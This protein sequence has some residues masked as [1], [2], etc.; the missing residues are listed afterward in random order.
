MARAGR[1]VSR[2]DAGTAAILGALI[3]LLGAVVTATVTVLAVRITTSGGRDLERMR[4]RRELYATFLH[5]SDEVRDAIHVASMGGPVD[6]GWATKL[7]DASKAYW[8]IR[9]V[10]PSMSKPASAL[11]DATDGLM[12]NV[13]RVEQATELEGGYRHVPI[14]S[15]RYPELDEVYRVSM[16]AFIEAAAADVGGEKRR[17]FRRT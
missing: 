8:E 6:D 11:K 1:T 16:L 5:S 2:V 14:D 15:T 9:I 10:A 7:S 3:G 4:W 12:R 17:F 13:F